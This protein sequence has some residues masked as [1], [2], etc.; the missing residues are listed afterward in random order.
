[1]QSKLVRYESNLI[2]QVLRDSLIVDLVLKKLYADN[3]YDD[4]VNMKSVFNESDTYEPYISL[5]K[6][7]KLVRKS[8]ELLCTMIFNELSCGRIMSPYQIMLHNTQ[9]ATTLFTLYINDT[10]TFQLICKEFNKFAFVVDQK[11][12]EF[13]EVAHYKEDAFMFID[14]LS[15]YYKPY[16]IIFSN[17]Q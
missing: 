4:I 8:Q 11:L 10:T 15:D 16:S 1:M 7:D 13:S 5:I 6:R 12:I 17:Q 2:D 3:C 14:K 9:I